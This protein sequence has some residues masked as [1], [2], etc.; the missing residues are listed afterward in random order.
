MSNQNTLE[1]GEYNCICDVCGWKIK[2]GDI[3]TRWDGLKVCELDWEPKH[4][5]LLIR[6]PRPQQA[7][8]F[9]RPEAPDVSC[10]PTYI[11]TAIGNQPT[12]IPSGTFNPATQ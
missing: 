3:K 9:T 7:V 4:P 1:F 11:S 2:S 5:S 6:P 10:G 12:T 8:P